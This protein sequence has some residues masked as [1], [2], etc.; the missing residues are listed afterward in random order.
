MLG[1]FQCMKGHHLEGL[2]G[3]M[4]I[5]SMGTFHKEHSHVPYSRVSRFLHKKVLIIETID[6][7]C[8]IFAG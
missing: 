5:S 1:C 2:V 6:Q 8:F 3:A 4:I 7:L